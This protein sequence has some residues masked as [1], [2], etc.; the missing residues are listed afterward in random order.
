VYGHSIPSV[1]GCPVQAIASEGGYRRIP[2][3]FPAK[4]LFIGVA[5]RYEVRVQP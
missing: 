1:T 2:T 3:P 5:E 4:G